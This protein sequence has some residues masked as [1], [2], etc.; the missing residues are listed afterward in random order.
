MA[1]V[2]ALHK[3]GL[4]FGGKRER[5]VEALRLIFKSLGLTLSWSTF[6]L[7]I[8]PPRS[9]V[10]ASFLLQADELHHPSFA[11]VNDEEAESS[12]M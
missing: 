6:G 8:R 12:P 10:C 7:W 11:D 5:K 9:C 1:D 3:C 4:G 2:T